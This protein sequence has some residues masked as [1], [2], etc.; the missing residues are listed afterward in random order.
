VDQYGYTRRKA[1]RSVKDAKREGIVKV[2]SIAV[3]YGL[4]AVVA[5][6]VI[7]STFVSGSASIVDYLMLVASLVQII[8]A[9]YNL[10]SS[11]K[12]YE[13]LANNNTWLSIEYQKA[14]IACKYTADKQKKRELFRR[15]GC[16]A[17][18]EVCGWALEFSRNEPGSPVS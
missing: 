5:I 15:T 4:T 11:T 9:G 10:Y 8:V 14:I 3:A 16:E 13:R 2:I 7:I 6:L 18:R 17:V 1:A 12:D